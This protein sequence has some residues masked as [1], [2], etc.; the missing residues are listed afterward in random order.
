[1]AKQPVRRRVQRAAARTSSQLGRGAA[2]RGSDLARQM[3][4]LDVPWA[5]SAPAQL[6]RAGLLAFVLGPLIA[7]YV[8]ARRRGHEIFR[9]LEP[10]VVLVANH[11]SHLDTPT[12]LHAMPRAWRRRTIV[13]AAADHFYQR[14]ST[15]SGVSLLLNTVPVA[16]SGGGADALDHVAELVGDGWN[17]LIYAEGTR[18]RDGQLARM[19]SGAALIAQRHG[20]PI[21]P[22]RV[23]GTHAA[24]PPDA[25]WPKRVRGRLLSRRHK[26]EVE[27][28]A[29]VMPLESEKPA[30][31][32]A[33]V[34]TFFTGEDAGE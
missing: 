25:S 22:V 29:P 10:P 8:Y 14:R 31:T 17:L 32:M 11:A 12:I 16:R 30:E 23:T 9:E 2:A 1:M 5:R 7:Y 33:R 24:M 15:A 20:I 6:I 27:F 4:K 26:V 34:S 28:G 18:S 21:V 13:A 3:R 19:K